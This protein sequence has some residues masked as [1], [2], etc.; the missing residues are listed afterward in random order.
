MLLVI[1]KANEIIN[2]DI[3]NIL[4]FFF[5]NNNEDATP[6]VIYDNVNKIG[7]NLNIP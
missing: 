4:P 7:T 2:N 5:S 1:N 3:Y 6:N